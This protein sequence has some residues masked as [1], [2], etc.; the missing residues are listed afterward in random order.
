MKRVGECMLWCTYRNERPISSGGPH[1][2]PCLR[3]GVSFPV[4]F[5]IH[6]VPASSK[7]LS[8]SYLVG[9]ALVL[10]SKI[11]MGSGDSRSGT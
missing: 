7:A 4:H 1:L 5:C 8:V 11:H 6:T 10:Q 9:E 2:S 3:H